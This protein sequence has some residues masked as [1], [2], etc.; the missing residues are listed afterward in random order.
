MS[1]IFAV[2]IG[3]MLL[4][5]CVYGRHAVIALNAVQRD[6]TKTGLAAVTG[7]VIRT[8]G[9]LQADNI[10]L[11]ISF[12]Q[13]RAQA[14]RVYIQLTIRIQPSAAS[15]IQCSPG[16]GNRPTTLLKQAIFQHKRVVE[17][18]A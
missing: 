18:L 1:A 3:Y 6:M 10:R 17:R 11:T 12:P 13:R 8:F 9:F 4:V 2:A 5:I 16:Q 7:A 14:H 15:S